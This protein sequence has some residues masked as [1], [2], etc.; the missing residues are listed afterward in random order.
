ML[1]GVQRNGHVR[2]AAYFARPHAGAVH[3]RVRAHLAFR[4]DD[5]RH[6]AAR[7]AEAGD[8]EVLEDTHA[9]RA[10]TPRERA[11]ARIGR[12]MMAEPVVV[13][14]EGRLATDVMR[15]APGRLLARSGAEGLLLVA[16][17]ARARGIAIKIEDGAMRAIDPAAVDP[18]DVEILG[19]MVLAAINEALRMAQELAARK[20]GGATGGLDLGGLGGLGLPGL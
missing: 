16:E 8:G 19:D 2:P 17:P 7:G 20:L 4:R 10:R 15:A 14:G 3:H 1:G 13:E 11:L 9:G 5:S 12:A 18:E 6:P